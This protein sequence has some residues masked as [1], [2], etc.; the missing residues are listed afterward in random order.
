MAGTLQGEV[1]VCVDGYIHVLRCLHVQQVK[2]P[3]KYE[4]VTLICFHRNIVDLTRPNFFCN[5]AKSAHS[6][7]KRQMVSSLGSFSD[8]RGEIDKLLM[9]QHMDIKASFVRSLN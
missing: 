6:R 2:P 1:R 8:N 4:L 7:L 5:K 9:L 3:T